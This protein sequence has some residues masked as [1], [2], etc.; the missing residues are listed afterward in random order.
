MERPY[1]SSA[2]GPRE[3]R[4]TSHEPTAT[5]GGRGARGARDRATA[6]NHANARGGKG[7]DNRTAAAERADHVERR[8]SRRRKGDPG[9]DR[10]QHQGA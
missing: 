10:T 2:Q 5:P 1:Q 7:N 3:A 6:H 9:T 4:A 8:T